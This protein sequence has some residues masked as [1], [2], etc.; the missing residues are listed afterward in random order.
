MLLGLGHALTIDAA[1][2]L[3]SDE[4]INALPRGTSGVTGFTSYVAESRAR[5]TTWTLISEG[6]LHEAER[7]RQ[8]RRRRHADHPGRRFGRAPPRI[9]RRSPTRRLASICST[10]P[11]TTAS[12][13]STPSSGRTTRWRRPRWPIR[14]GERRRPAHEGAGGQRATLPPPAVARHRHPGKRLRSFEIRNRSTVV[15]QHLRAMRAEAEVA[16]IGWPA[17]FPRPRRPGRR[18]V[19]PAHRVGAL[20]PVTAV[21]GN[22]MTVGAPLAWIG[23]MA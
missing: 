9:C 3:T 2:G 7:H 16:R 14:A 12:A 23:E 5:G 19:A 13:R 11:G 6:A 1:Q 15:Q 17:L 18:R 10:P 8:A 21:S 20:Q 4:H 22:V